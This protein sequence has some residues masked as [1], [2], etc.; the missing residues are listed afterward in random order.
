[1]IAFSKSASWQS[2]SATSTLVASPVITRALNSASSRV[3][4]GPARMRDR[5]TMVMPESGPGCAMPRFLLRWYALVNSA[6]REEPHSAPLADL[7]VHD[8][9]KPG[10]LGAARGVAGIAV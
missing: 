2:N 9:A 8:R 3:Q 6:E 7:S 5:S 4:Y 1:M 10:K